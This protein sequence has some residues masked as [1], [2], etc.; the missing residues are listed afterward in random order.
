MRLNLVICLLGFSFFQLSENTE[1]ETFRI[2][3]FAQGTTYQ[4]QYYATEK[5]VSK[6]QIEKILSAI[7]SSLSLYKPYSLISRFN[8]SAS[9]IELD[10]HLKKVVKKSLEISKK[11]RGAF[12]IT[13]QPLV[14]AWGFGTST[15]DVLPDSASIQAIL[16]CVGSEKI[17]IH[18]NCLLKTAACVSIDVN[19]IAQ[20]YTVDVLAAYLE[21]KGIGHYLVELGGEI[22]I[23][24]RKQPS[25]ELMAIG[26]EG[27]G[28]DDNHAFPIQTI[29]GLE[30]GAI[31]S[32]GNYQKFLQM[33]ANR[34]S[35]LIDPK[36]GYP[37][38]N[39]MISVTVWAED[40]MTA[41]GYDNALMGMGIEKG[42][43]FA[44]QQKK[45]EAYF[46]YHRE[47]GSIADTATTGFYKLIK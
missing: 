32:S 27:P 35:H 18:E 16:T 30:A 17:S 34:F 47:D 21:E 5:A 44:E 43:E 28:G 37:I 29:I 33:G 36:T 4:I 15:I 14:Q 39:E 38:R 42:L 26:I 2:R 13:I 45:L 40:A 46:I 31:T 41:D 25:G 3:G 20:G 8:Q 23:K 19:G 22:R 7:D 10:C 9:G 24:G 6:Q 12:D 1:A 11:T